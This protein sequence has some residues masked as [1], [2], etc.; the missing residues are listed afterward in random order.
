M[1]HAGKPCGGKTLEGARRQRIDTRFPKV[2]HGVTCLQPER[3]QRSAG[4]PRLG[5]NWEFSARKF[6]TNATP[7]PCRNWPE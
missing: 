7:S 1:R 5:P 2:S 4:D 6:A 3:R